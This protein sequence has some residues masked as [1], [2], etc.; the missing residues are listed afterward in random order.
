MPLKPYRFAIITDIHYGTD[1][2]ID[3]YC[4]K[5]PSRAIS[6]VRYF[7]NQ[8][9]KLK[10]EFVVQL[11]NAIEDDDSD[12]DA[13]NLEKIFD[14]LKESTVPVHHVVGSH[15]QVNLSCEQI[16]QILKLDS[17]YHSWDGGGFHFVALFA[18][19]DGAELTIDQAQLAWLETD[20]EEAKFP[21]LVFLHCPVDEQ[22]L[23]ENY[24]FEKQPE[25]CF[26]KDCAEFRSL[27]ER[28]GKVKL[29]I[30]GHAHQNNINEFAG[31]HYVT[32]QSLVENMTKT[33]KTP[34]ESYSV[35]T[36]TER[37]IRIEVL[38]LAQAEFR[39]AMK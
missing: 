1:K 9:I 30:S 12:E 39:I 36:L 34:S 22:D 29:V 15:E 18:K 26:L 8:M 27:L 13:D 5:L 4:K 38:G 14:V 3:G 31:I 11:G 17:L 2:P 10:P 32:V 33:G 20:I 21:V 25:R 16:K 28:S 19:D 23:F 35:V 7:V 6:L 37:E 24:Y